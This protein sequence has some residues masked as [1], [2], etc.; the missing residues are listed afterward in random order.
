MLFSSGAAALEAVHHLVQIL[1]NTFVAQVE[2]FQVVAV[3]EPG[4]CEVG[5]EFAQFGLLLVHRRSGDHRIARALVL[6]FI[7]QQ[8][9]DTSIN[10]VFAASLTSN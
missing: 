3:V 9:F 5:L 7:W 10:M 2:W 4:C 1:R 6:A 8:K